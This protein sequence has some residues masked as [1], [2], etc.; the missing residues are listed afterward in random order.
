MS[1][2]KKSFLGGKLMET[3]NKEYE[4]LEEET[5]IAPGDERSQENSVRCLKRRVLNEIVPVF[6][7]FSREFG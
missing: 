1:Y 3:T 5:G 6:N 4:I 2:K 7:S